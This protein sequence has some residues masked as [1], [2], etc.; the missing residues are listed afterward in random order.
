MWQQ[1][2]DRRI[3]EEN[4]D[5]LRKYVEFLRTRATDNVLS[6]SYY[7]DWVFVER[8]PGEFVSD[9][10]YYYDAQI[11]ARI[12]EILGKSSDAETY[13][14]LLGQIKEAFNRK[15]LNAGAGNYANG[16][17]TASAM[18][19]YLDLVPKDHRGAVAFNLTNDIVYTHDTHL[20]TG[21][22][23][24]KY[25]M[26]ALTMIGRS[27]LAYDLATQTTYPSWG[28][29]VKR[30]ATTLWELWQEKTGPSMNSHDHAMFGSVGAWFYQ[31]LAGIN[32][33]GDGAGDVGYRQI[34]IAPQ[35]VEDLE[36]ASGTVETVRGT[37]SSSWSHSPGVITVEVAIPVGSD[38]NV[39][40]PKDI[41]MTEVTIQEGD[42]VVWEKGHYVPGVAGIT[43]A[44]QEH[45]G[46]TFD[47]GS[48]HYL[49]KLSGQ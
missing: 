19:L 15:F 44:T 24:I 39:F 34:R 29:M 42:R 20:T 3:L 36:S 38:A 45:G 26:P 16:T 6:Y 8:T 11:L 13:S 17:Q 18:A 21:F 48:G 28:Y 27:D 4:Y 33:A 9:A 35:I 23:G 7:G 31:A 1:Y 32:I 2:G 37:V 22:I 5:G 30:G 40:V 14:Q 43:A 46:F 25:L 12:A 41:Y 47:V 49:F 10:Y